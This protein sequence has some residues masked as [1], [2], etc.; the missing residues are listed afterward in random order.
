MVDCVGSE[1]FFF[2]IGVY[3]SVVFKDLFGGRYYLTASMYTL[4]NEPNCT[5]KFNFGP[6]FE[7]FP[8]RISKIG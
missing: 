5:V 6:D 7:F 1:I 2:K 4:P 3:Q 8:L